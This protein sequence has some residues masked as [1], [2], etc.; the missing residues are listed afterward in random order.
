M[1]ELVGALAHLFERP[2]GEAGDVGGAQEAVLGDV[3]DDVGVAVGE[4]DGSR[5]ALGALAA[6]FLGGIDQVGR[7]DGSIYR[8]S[9]MPATIGAFCGTNVAAARFRGNSAK[10]EATSWAAEFYSGYWVYRFRSSSFSL[11]FL[12]DAASR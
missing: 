11:S 6:G 10:G 1:I 12:T 7:H 4:L 3:A 8:V 9:A 2:A 5:R